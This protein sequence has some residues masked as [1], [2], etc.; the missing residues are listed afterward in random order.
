[1]LGVNPGGW[2]SR[3]YPQ[4]LAWGREIRVVSMKYCI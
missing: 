1:M 4:I 3:S 2:G